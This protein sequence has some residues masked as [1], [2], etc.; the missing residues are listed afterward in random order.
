MKEVLKQLYDKDGRKA[1]LVIIPI[2]A[3]IQLSLNTEHTLTGN[4]LSFFK[5]YFGVMFIAFTMIY[6]GN[7][8]K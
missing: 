2:L 1:Q 3:F 6:L 4:I 8:V 7:N 5:M